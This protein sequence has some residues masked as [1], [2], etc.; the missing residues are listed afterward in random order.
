MSSVNLF[1]IAKSGMFANRSAL[2]TTG[3]N[4]ANVNTEGYSRQR[5]EQ[6]P[7]EPVGIGGLNLGTGVKVSQIRRINDEY[8][9]R[10]IQNESKFLGQYEE[11]GI[12]LGQAENIFNEI[13]S[14]GMNRLIV[15]FFNEFRKLGNEPESEALRATVRESAH[16]IVGDFHR[17]SR[18][19]RDI[20]KNIDRRMVSDVREANELV[21]RIGHLNLM[22]RKYEMNSGESPD[23]RDERDLA[24]QKLATLLDVSVATNETGELTISVAGVGPLVSG[25]LVNKLYLET[26]KADPE[27]GTPEGSYDVKLENLVQ[28]TI[29][30]RLKNGKFA[31][32]IEA[33]DTILGQT[34]QKIDQ[35]AYGLATKVNE[36][37]AQ[38]YTLNNT[39][40]IDFFKN[41]ETL[42]DAAERLS[43]SDA[44]REDS[45][46]IAT[47]LIP[48]APGDNRLV[49]LIAGLQH[50][51]TLN[52]GLSTFDDYYNST[53]SSL[54]TLS[55]SNRH[56]LEQ[57]QH[58]LGQLS[59]LREEISGVSLDEETANLIQYQHAFDASA[60]VIKAAND[61]L[62]EVLNIKR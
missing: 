35:L 62:D 17:I 38:G 27:S 31:G 4:I 33:R 55:Q 50:E 19:I 39:T 12:A 44:V 51:K 34:L 22:I 11:K 52:G 32:L 2:A 46:N 18:G 45:N 1:N 15:K 41:P 48:D 58:T 16:Q 8:L 9:T 3:H 53:V 14:D 6:T 42:H 23:M 24:V 57:Q 5:V 25:S 47:A 36:I 49:Q 29:T 20:Q 10:Q 43:L 56:S 40:G 30:H 61:M 26:R 60:K 54:A 21:E 37:H 13:T 28:P 7:N 59:K